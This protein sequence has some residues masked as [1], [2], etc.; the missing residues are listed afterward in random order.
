MRTR[1]SVEFFCIKSPHVTDY[2]VADKCL[3]VCELLNLY[4]WWHLSTVVKYI[5]LEISWP[6]CG[7]L[8]I[9]LNTVL[10]QGLEV[11]TFPNLTHMG[12]KQ[13]SDIFKA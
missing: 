4:P 12:R 11:C 5:H 9:F 10:N 2:L 8:G 1:L 6:V 7:K 3:S 13:G